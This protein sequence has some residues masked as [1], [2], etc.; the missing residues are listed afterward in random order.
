MKKLSPLET[1]ITHGYI[2]WG[3]KPTFAI[4]VE[5]DKGS[6]E[7]YFNGNKKNQSIVSVQS[8]LSENVKQYGEDKFLY[9]QLQLEKELI[10]YAPHKG[11]TVWGQAEYAQNIL[12]NMIANG[13]ETH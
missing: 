9:I 1:L 13:V 6:Y 2:E 7:L 5:R 8:F 4:L 10:L 11:A 3:L 12:D